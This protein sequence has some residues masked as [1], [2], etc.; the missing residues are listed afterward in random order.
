MLHSAK[1]HV[2]LNVFTENNFIFQT[3][4]CVRVPLCNMRLKEALDM[5]S[6]FCNALQDRVP[7]WVYFSGCCQ[8]MER[9]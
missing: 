8:I 9:P 6:L 2:V 3:G 4:H 5:M 7:T 1:R